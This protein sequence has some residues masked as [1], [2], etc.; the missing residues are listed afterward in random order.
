[1]LNQAPEVT[2]PRFGPRKLALSGWQTRPAAPANPTPCSAKE[3]KTGYPSMPQPWFKTNCIG[4][5]DK[6]SDFPNFT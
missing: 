5:S 2:M 4:R 1:M 6:I 3:R